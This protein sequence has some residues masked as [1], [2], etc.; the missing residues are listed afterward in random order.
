MQIFSIVTVLLRNSTPNRI[1]FSPYLMRLF[2]LVHEP[3]YQVENSRNNN[4]VIVYIL[5][6]C[7]IFLFHSINSFILLRLFVCFETVS[8]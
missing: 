8:L 4:Y 3:E 1:M 2:L 6:Y 7:I 5:L